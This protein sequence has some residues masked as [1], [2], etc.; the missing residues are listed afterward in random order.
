ML[1][2]RLTNKILPLLVAVLSA[3]LYLLSISNHGLPS[4]HALLESCLLRLVL[5]IA[6]HSLRGPCRQPLICTFFET[7]LP[8]S[9]LIASSSGIMIFGR[10]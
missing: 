6:L 7:L 4:V 9:F 10:Q 2:A 8:I 1:S 5:F 3:G